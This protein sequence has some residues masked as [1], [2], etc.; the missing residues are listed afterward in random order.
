MGGAPLLVAGG[1]SDEVINISINQ[2]WVADQCAGG[3]HLDFKTYPNRTH[4]S[5]L[6]ATS[7][8]TNELTNWTADRFAGKP[9]P[10][11]C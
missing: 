1:T 10:S 7:P 5:V 11:T 4:I 3:H 2:K 6:D 9:A 8:L